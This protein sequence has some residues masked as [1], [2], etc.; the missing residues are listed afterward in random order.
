MFQTFNIANKNIL[1][2]NKVEKLFYIVSVMNHVLA[3]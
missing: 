1:M 3:Q 2:R